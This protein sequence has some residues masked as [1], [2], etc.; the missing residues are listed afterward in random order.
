VLVLSL[1]F[2]AL[3]G[4]S[5]H[6]ARATLVWNAVTNPVPSGYMLYYGTVGGNYTTTVNVGNQ[7]S[8]TV[9][10]LQAGVSAV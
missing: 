8:Y 6:A 7:T 3:Q 5:T 10:G 2:V 4:V 1:L 9:T